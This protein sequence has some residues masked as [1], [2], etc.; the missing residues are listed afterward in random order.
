MFRWYSTTAE[1]VEDLLKTKT[2]MRGGIDTKNVPYY[3]GRVFF[4][5]QQLVG[6][7]RLHGRDSYM[8]SLYWSAG[9]YYYHRSTEFDLLVYEDPI[10]A[11]KYAKFAK[12]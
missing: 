6:R 11:K 3:I 8:E 5:N 7:I 10:A 12:N 9:G 1:Q 4:R 2:A